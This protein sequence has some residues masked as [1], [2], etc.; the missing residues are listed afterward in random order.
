MDYFRFTEDNEPKASQGLYKGLTIMADLHTDW[1]SASSVDADFQGFL[2]YVA[3]GNSFPLTTKRGFTL[4][5]GHEN[6]VVIRAVDIQTA[7]ETRSSVAPTLRNCYFPDEKPLDLH[8]NYSQ[9][10]CRL[11][12]AL[13]YAQQEWN[14]TCTPWNFPTQDKPD[15]T[16]C[17]P[18][19]A[20]HIERTMFQEMPDGKCDHCLPD[21]TETQFSTFVTSVPFRRCDYKNLGVSYLCDFKDP[22]LPEPRIWGRQ[23]LTEYDENPAYPIAP[24]YITDQVRLYCFNIS[25]NSS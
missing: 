1:I 18:W 4:K 9:T 5:A 14:T 7:E 13:Q 19:S 22:Y 11:E 12:C 2:A 20:F 3:P 8:Q 6:R 15:Q 24:D 25:T 16:M 17:D 10:N 23:V 21:C